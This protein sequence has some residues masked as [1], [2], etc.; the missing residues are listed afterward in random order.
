MVRLSWRSPERLS[1]WRTVFPEA[2]GIG[3]GAGEHGERSVVTATPACD[4]AASTVAATTG[5]TPVKVNR[6]APRRDDRAD[7]LLVVGDGPAAVSGEER[8]ELARLRRR[9]AEPE[10]AGYGAQAMRDALTAQMTTLPEQ[11][12]RSLTWDRGKGTRSAR[13]TEDRHR[14]QRLLRRPAQSLAARYE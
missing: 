12:R 9:V 4:Q 11:L 2:A 13:A 1:R 6:S 10:L 5:P 3:A 8:A 7:R 14:Y